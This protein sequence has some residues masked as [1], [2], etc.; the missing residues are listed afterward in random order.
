[1]M[2]NDED[3]PI[4]QLLKKSRPV[5]LKRPKLSNSAHSILSESLANEEPSEEPLTSAPKTE[6]L[7]ES[8]PL[9]IFEQDETILSQEET[10]S[11]NDTIYLLKTTRHKSS[12]FVCQEC[13]KIFRSALGLHRHIKKCKEIDTKVK[14]EELTVLQV[15]VNLF[16]LN[17][18]SFFLSLSLS[19]PG[20][21][22]LP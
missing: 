6:S 1:M 14:D 9:D 13:N 19:T 15:L 8:L 7:L 17:Y 4:A 3:M 11:C 5:K 10:P 21:R 16:I 18:Y 20:C 12:K 2:D 22:P